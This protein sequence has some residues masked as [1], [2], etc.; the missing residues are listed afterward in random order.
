MCYKTI[1]TLNLRKRYA[2][3]ISGCG[4]DEKNIFQTK[5]LRKYAFFSLC[6]GMK[7]VI[8]YFKVFK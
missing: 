8:I 6:L 2:Q 3:K 7:Q 5:Y 4:F 1:N